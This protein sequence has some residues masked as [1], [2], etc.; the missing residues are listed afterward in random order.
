MARIFQDTREKRELG[1][2]A[3]WWVEWRDNGRRR[4]QKVG[5]KKQAREIAALKDTEKVQRRN[6]LV[7]DKLW[8][9]FV[10]EYEAVTLPKM[11]SV[12]SRESATEALKLFGEYMRPKYVGL[13]DY[14]TLDTFATKRLKDRGRKAG[15][16]LAAATVRKDLRTIRA[17]LAV[18][19]DWKYLSVVP[20]MP[21]V[22]GLESDKR[23]VSMEHFEAMLTILDPKTKDRYEPRLPIIANAPFEPA[24]WWRALLVTLWV[25][26]MRIGAALAL[27]WS[28]V[29]LEAG[30]VMSRAKDNKAKKD[31]RVDVLP[32]VELLRPLKGF[33]PRVFPWDRNRTALY[34]HFATLQVAAGIHLDCPGDHEHTDRCHVYSFHDFRRAHATFNYGRVSDRDLQAQM[35]HAS[36]ATTQ[37]YIKFAE[38]HQA[39]RYDVLLPKSMTTAAG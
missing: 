21:D 22:A 18:A 14:R 20:K 15:D 23:F 6:G 32:A 38:Q 19:H 34:R 37:R 11:R 8:T 7:I 28:D 26:G 16:T 36:F 29:D 10:A 5:S 13:V 12:H 30:T 4:S 24:D 25:S 31:Q 35:G 3:P 9:E 27:K 1:S 39:K 33:D 17:A 2:K